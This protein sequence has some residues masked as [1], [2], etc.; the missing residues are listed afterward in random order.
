[1]NFYLFITSLFLFSAKLL[2]QNVAAYKDYKNY[3]Y[4]FDKGETKELEYKEVFSFKTGKDFVAYINTDN[5]LKIYYDGKAEIVEVSQPKNYE[6]SA[7][8]CVW[9]MDKRLMVF[10]KGVTTKLS[11]WAAFYNVTD[12]MV[13]FTEQPGGDFKVYYKGEIIL[14]EE[15]MV[16]RSINSYT[17]GKN[18]IAYTDIANTFKIFYRGKIYD[19]GTTEIVRGAA[20]EDIVSFTNKY[21]NEFS[22]FYK[23][24]VILLETN[25]PKKTGIANGMIAYVDYGGTFKLFYD[26][27]TVDLLS[28]EPDEWNA[29]GNFLAY[30]NGPDI[31]TFWNGK[32]YTLESNARSLV[33]SIFPFK[34]G[35]G[36]NSI[37]WTDKAGKLKLFFKGEIKTN[38]TY[39]IVTDVEVVRDIIVFK[40]GISTTQVYWEGKVY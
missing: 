11:D 4:I 8:L 31:L 16:N 17:F 21:T 39:E 35:T 32:V 37:F 24:E 15:G 14:L 28:N 13:I 23:G 29:V 30:T 19:I 5:S 9:K 12:S 27:G 25:L 6:V 36:E 26:Y 38:I 3:F 10:D 18:T 7:N 20:A 1:M 33:P 22:V 40:S 34:G 2:S